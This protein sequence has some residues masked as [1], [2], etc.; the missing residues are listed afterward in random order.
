MGDATG[1]A[2]RIDAGEWSIEE[3]P[4]VLFRRTALTA[5]L[6]EPDPTGEIGHLWAWLNAED[7]DRPLL[8]A[9]LIAAAF[10][11][12]SHPVASLVGEQGSGKT[13][14]Q[15]VLVS[16]I[17]PSPVPLRTAPRDIDSWITAAVG[18]WLV[19][20]DNLST[21]PAWLSDCL[22]RAVTGDGTVRRKLYTDNDMHVLS[23]RRCVILNGIDLGTIRGDLAERLLHIKLKTIPDEK[24]HTEAEMCARWE[25]AHPK[26]LGA[27]L[28]AI[29]EVKLRLPSVELE[30]KP[31]MADFALLLACVDR[32]LGTR[33]LERYLSMQR[34][35]AADTLSGDTFLAAVQDFLHSEG[36]T[37]FRGSAAELLKLLPRPE[38]PPA[39]WPTDP[40]SVTARLNRMAPVMRKTGWHVESEQDGHSKLTIWCLVPSA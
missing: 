27:V 19:G 25:Q 4:P 34:A 30:K 17:D 2:I 21:I 5:A 13:T 37:R 9:W 8:L 12:I 26:I 16:I 3:R 33:G 38:R 23:F 35:L 15:K 32:M 1:R 31:R 24:R 18:S 11:D 29:A 6:P 22:C 10:P 20:L 40:R 39:G 36:R 14:A 7:E 28:A